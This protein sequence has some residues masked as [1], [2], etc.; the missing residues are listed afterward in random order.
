MAEADTK[1]PEDLRYTKDHEWVR[2]EGN[3]ATLGITDYAQESLT[4]VVYAE[5]PDVGDEFTAG[6]SMGVVESVKSVSDIFAPFAG[7]V[8]A[9]NEKLE[10]APELLN[11]DPYGDGWYCVIE[12][13]DTG[14]TEKLLTPDQYKQFLTES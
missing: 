10:D 12:L 13:Q 2:V 5:V 3:R 6:D 9:V 7:K 14:E 11:D 4:D 8:V 1:I